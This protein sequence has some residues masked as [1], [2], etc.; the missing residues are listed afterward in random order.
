MVEDYKFRLEIPIEVTKA[1]SGGNPKGQ[2]FFKNPQYAIRAE[3]PLVNAFGTMRVSYEG[4]PGSYTC[5]IITQPGTMERVV[6][7]PT[8]YAE[9]HS[10]IHILDIG[11]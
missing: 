9:V 4:P 1:N 11:L 7:L 8:E 6:Q 5:V 2:F 3:S 10:M